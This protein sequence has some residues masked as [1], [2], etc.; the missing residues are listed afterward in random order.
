[1]EQDVVGEFQQDLFEIPE[2]PGREITEDATYD[3]AEFAAGTVQAVHVD[4]EP[5]GGVPVQVE[6]CHHQMTVGYAEVRQCF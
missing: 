3:G 1:L 6:F 5:S 4:L 2:Q